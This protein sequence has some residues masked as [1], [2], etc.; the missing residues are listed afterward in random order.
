MCKYYAYK[1]GGLNKN[2][3]SLCHNYTFNT[4]KQQSYEEEQ[5]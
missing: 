3:L 4:F 1:F 5:V 2:L